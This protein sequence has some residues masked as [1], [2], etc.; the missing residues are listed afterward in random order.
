MTV[1]IMSRNDIAANWTTNDPILREGEMGLE[2]DSHRF[3]VGDGIT[4]WSLLPYW[5]ESGRPQVKIVTAPTYM[6]IGSD[7][8]KL[9]LFTNTTGCLITGPVNTT[10]ELPNGFICHL[11]QEAASP[12]GQIEFQVEAGATTR[13]AIGLKT[14]TQFAS[15]SII[16]QAL[17]TYK[18]IGDAVA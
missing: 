11:H 7:E 5:G 18:I 6:L 4:I 9:I 3:K 12:D 14:R 17:N 2:T 8:S 16:V 13:A 15:L 1:H 10:E